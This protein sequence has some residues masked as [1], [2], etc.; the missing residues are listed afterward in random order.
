MLN[1][2]VKF[3]EKGVTLVELLATVILISIVSALAYSI[4]FQGFNNQQRIKIETELRDEADLIMASFVRD[5]FILK[6][7]EITLITP[8]GN[9]VNGSYLKVTK[10]GTS[11]VEYKTGFENKAVF[12]KGQPVHF[13]SD[14]IELVPPNCAENSPTLIT[15]SSNGTGYN[16]KFTLKSKNNKKNLEMQF[17]NTI[18]VIDDSVKTSGTNN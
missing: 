5:L 14:N 8:C 2:L 18:K 9:T 16:I 3:N 1:R 12:V 7:S 10:K 4:F 17:T 6:Q 13:Y 11:P 15:K